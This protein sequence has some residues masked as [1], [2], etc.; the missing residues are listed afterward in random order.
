MCKTERYSLSSSF[1]T[2]LRVFYSFSFV[3]DFLCGFLKQK[4]MKLIYL[5]FSNLIN[6]ESIY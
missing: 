4:K 3:P 2:I 1:Y 6:H 5:C